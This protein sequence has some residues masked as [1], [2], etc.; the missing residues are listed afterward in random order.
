VGVPDRPNV[1]ARDLELSQ[2]L[3]S[4]A[5][6][7]GDVLLVAVAVRLWGV[8][9]RRTVASRLLTV[10]LVALLAADTVAAGSY[11][12]TVTPLAD[13]DGAVVTH[14]PEAAVR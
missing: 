13:G 12:L 3:V 2:R 14:R 11:E 7:L 4:I 6:P 8:G 9:G 1:R 10:G 5:Y